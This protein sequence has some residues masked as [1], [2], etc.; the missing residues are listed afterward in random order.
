MFLD[1]FFGRLSKPEIATSEDMFL[2]F[3]DARSIEN[4]LR[5]ITESHPEFAIDFMQEVRGE[6]L[7]ILKTGSRHPNAVIYGQESLFGTWNRHQV[8]DALAQVENMLLEQGV[9]I[10]VSTQTQPVR[11]VDSESDDAYGNRLK[12]DIMSSV[13]DIFEQMENRR[14]DLFSVELDY[15]GVLAEHFDVSPAFMESLNKLE[16][17]AML[18]RSYEVLLVIQ[19]VLTNA[20]RDQL[21]D[22]EQDL[23]VFDATVSFDSIIAA[24]IPISS[25]KTINFLKQTLSSLEQYLESINTLSGSAEAAK[26]GSLSFTRDQLVDVYDILNKY[27]NDINIADIGLDAESHAGVNAVIREAAM[28]GRLERKDDIEIRGQQVEVYIVKGVAS[29]YGAQKA[30]A[31]IRRNAIYIAE[32]AYSETLARHEALEVIAWQKKAMELMG[33]PSQM[34]WT[35]IPASGLGIT[36]AKAAQ[37]LREYMRD[38]PEEAIALEAEYHRL[39]NVE[40]PVETGLEL[41]T[42]TRVVSVVD[43]QSLQEQIGATKLRIGS[44]VSALQA[45]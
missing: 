18:S 28:D 15:V 24:L 14:F 20:T 22:S 21:I 6:L 29:I 36:R 30:H 17:P 27:L 10:T 3:Q 16:L 38:N 40:A 19:A 1:S 2:A 13:L 35:D 34:K 25:P 7:D 5:A 33:L 39:A 41:F 26:F 8:Q 23:A 37:K 43:Q 12:T 4:I 42:D 32:F 31:G 45:A 44:I 9:P 11:R